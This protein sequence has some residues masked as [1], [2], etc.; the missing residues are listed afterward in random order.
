MDLIL[1]AVLILINGVFAMAEI[2]VVSSRSARLQRLIDEGNHGAVAALKLHGEPSR[3]LSTIQVGITSVGILNGAIGE[4]ALADPLA[5][6]LAT[7]PVVSEYARGLALA[8]TVVILTYF[9]VVVG[10]LVPKRLALLAP[11]RF[12]AVFA[13]PMTWLA[14]FARPL[15]W[16][17][18]SSGDLLLRLFKADRG[19]EPPV[20]DEEIEV[21]MEQGAE[22]GVFHESEQAIVSNVL[23]LDELTVAAI[24][25]PRTDLYSVDLHD[26]EDEIR[27]AISESPHNRIVVCEDGLDNVVGILQRGDLLAPALAGQGLDVRGAMR[28]PVFVPRSVSTTH[29]L[30]SMRMTR[31]QSALAIDEYGTV[32]GIVTLNDVFAAIV[33]DMPVDSTFEQDLV[34]RE[35]GS[36][37]VDGGETVERLKGA[38]ELEADLPGEDDNAFHSVG[39][40]VMHALGRVPRITDHFVT[41]GWR[42]EVMDMD[43]R[44][45]DKV[46][47]SRNAPTTKPL[48]EKG[49]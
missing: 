45:V 24:M 27:R 12:A 17:F 43:G 6:W 10:E 20:T 5:A 23:R 8:S 15:V 41:H 38:L 44:R 3:F 46:L 36:W 26:S 37:L 13:R 42:F 11:E 25:T 33:G 1:I 16:L 28:P 18:S 49:A 48:P 40:F 22:A 32:Q 21:L 4:T 29:L 7:M 9:S 30:E 47:V 35:D 19:E 14:R 31:T 39:G 34:R 2:A